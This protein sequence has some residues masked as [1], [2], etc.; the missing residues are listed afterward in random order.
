MDKDGI[1]KISKIEKITSLKPEG[2]Q[3]AEKREEKTESAGK[4]EKSKPK[5]IV[6]ITG[7]LSRSRIKAK[8]TL[9][10]AWNA[11]TPIM[12]EDASW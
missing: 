11:K 8:L 1:L 2:K 9:S 10:H 7:A 12:R 3:K 6:T 5:M 4:T